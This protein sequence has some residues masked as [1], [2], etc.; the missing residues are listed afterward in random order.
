[1][2][3]WELKKDCNKIHCSFMIKTLLFDKKRRKFLSPTKNIYQKPTAYV[4]FNGGILEA[5]S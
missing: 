2:S 5:F 3:Q 1:M 4:I